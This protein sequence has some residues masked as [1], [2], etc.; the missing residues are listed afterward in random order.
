MQT[1]LITFLVGLLLITFILIGSGLLMRTGLPVDIGSELRMSLWLG[2][3][4][5]V[6]IIAGLNLLMPVREMPVIPML[7]LLSL[8]SVLVWC[9]RRK[10]WHDK[11]SLSWGVSPSTRAG[12]PVFKSTWIL[13]ASMLVVIVALFMWAGASTAWP[14]TNDDTGGYHLAAISFAWEYPTI[15]GLGNLH[16]RYGLNFAMWPFAAALG[17]VFSEGEGLRFLNLTILGALLLEFALRIARGRLNPTAAFLAITIIAA[18]PIILWKPG[19]WFVS[20][21]PDTTVLLLTLAMTAYFL[22]AMATRRPVGASTSL[23]IVIGALVVSLR[24]LMA[25]YVVVMLAALAWNHWRRGDDAA[26][27]RATSP[28]QPKTRLSYAIM[29]VPALAIG[30]VHLVRDYVLTGWFLFPLAMF[31]ADVTWRTPDPT[32]LRELI[33]AWAKSPGPDW[34][35]AASGWGWVVSWFSKQMALGKFY[36]ALPVAMVLLAVLIVAIGHRR[37]KNFTLVH[38]WPLVAVM[39]PALLTCIAWIFAGPD[40]RFVWGPLLAIGG[41][42]LAAALARPDAKSSNG[43]GQAGGDPLD[44]AGKW[45]MTGAMALVAIVLFGASVWRGPGNFSTHDAPIKTVLG[46]RATLTL[47]DFPQLALRQVQLTDGTPVR[48]GECWNTPNLC[49][50]ALW[51]DPVLVDARIASGFRQVHR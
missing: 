2:M 18:L 14:L 12:S 46:M 42:S 45:V 34:A 11:S 43:P 41:I 38:P 32:P 33:T 10:P 4:S 17:H 28:P 44:V 3:V 48:Q 30:L 22:D 16:N 19:N 27:E 9:W 40:P 25:V 24:P 23:V 37:G 6:A 39:M 31:P 5:V 8:L 29:L 49:T 21:S 47:A 51:G 1:L 50:P 15:P 7:M 36:V 35:S 20:P 26:G 13:I